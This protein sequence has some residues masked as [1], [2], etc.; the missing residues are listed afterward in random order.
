[1]GTHYDTLELRHDASQN[2]IKKAFLSKAFL[3]HPDRKTSESSEEKFKQVNEA[4]QVLSSEYKRKK[5]DESLAPKSQVNQQNERWK[6]YDHFWSGAKNTDYNHRTRK[7]SSR[8]NVYYTVYYTKNYDYFP[9]FSDKLSLFMFCCFASQLSLSYISSK[10]LKVNFSLFDFMYQ[11]I[12]TFILSYIYVSLTFS[13]SNWIKSLIRGNFSYNTS[14]LS[15]NVLCLISFY[16]VFSFP[17]SFFNGQ[18]SFFQNLELALG[19]SAALVN[20]CIL[21]W[22]KKVLVEAFTRSS[23]FLGALLTSFLAFFVFSSESLFFT[24]FDFFLSAKSYKT[25]NSELNFFSVGI[26][27][28]G[29][30]SSLMGYAYSTL[31]IFKSKLNRS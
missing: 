21:F 15:N 18:S 30:V 10:M 2:E 1:M 9:I 27:Y 7:R 5:Y 25:T 4:Y 14:Q 17:N 24:I 8:D 23:I 6:T 29:L 31:K 20:F 22:Y 13:L 28:S 12:S 11:I 16:F 3:Y 19:F 26:I